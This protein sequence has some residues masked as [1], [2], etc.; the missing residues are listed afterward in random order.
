MLCI[1]KEVSGGT[2]VPSLQEGFLASDCSVRAVPLPRNTWR[3][4]KLG[5]FWGRF[6]LNPF[7]KRGNISHIKHS[8]KWGMLRCM[9][10]SHA[11]IVVL[12]DLKAE[13]LWYN[14]NMYL[15]QSVEL[16]HSTL[17]AKCSGV[18]LPY[19]SCTACIR[20]IQKLDQSEVLHI[21]YVSMADAKFKTVSKN[22]WILINL[23]GCTYFTV[24]KTEA[25]RIHWQHYT[26]QPRAT[27]RLMVFCHLVLNSIYLMIF[28]VTNANGNNAGTAIPSQ[29]KCY[30]EATTTNN[31]C[32][33][34][35]TG[36]SPLNI[37]KFSMFHFIPPKTPSMKYNFFSGLGRM[38]KR[39]AFVCKTTLGRSWFSSHLQLF[40][41][42][43]HGISYWGSAL[44]PW[45]S[46]FLKRT[47]EVKLSCLNKKTSSNV[48]LIH[49]NYY[50]NIQSSCQDVYFFFHSLYFLTLFLSWP[51]TKY[52]YTSYLLQYPASRFLVVSPELH[53]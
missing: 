18:L 44:W 31:P 35:L 45:S 36:K 12:F 4:G 49:Y 28:Y 29:N 47:N 3:C 21:H 50:E 40:C 20:G 43:Q 9:K 53:K 34:T 41:S 24:E 38:H 2:E 16:Q 13:Q 8:V 25:Q 22:K 27:P 15:L 51:F 1:S 26:T 33:P 48:E 14:T 42:R 17:D 23:M 7:K 10:N 46:F 37:S 19:V 39:T 11:L 5:K 32:W 52:I 30:S 6:A